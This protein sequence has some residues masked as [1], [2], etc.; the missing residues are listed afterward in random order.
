[1]AVERSGI[2]K[3][4]TEVSLCTLMPISACFFI[5]GFAPVDGVSF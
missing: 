2:A 1:M 5:L 3:D 4:V